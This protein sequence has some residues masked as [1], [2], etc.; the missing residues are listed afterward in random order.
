V[1]PSEFVET[2]SELYAKSKRDLAN[3][4]LALDR[5]LQT[6]HGLQAQVE[7]LQQE[8]DTYRLLSRD[9]M[10]QRDALSDEVETLRQGVR[11]LTA[12]ACNRMS[13]ST[14]YELVGKIEHLEAAWKRV[15]VVLSD[16]GCSC[17]FVELEDVIANPDDACLGHRIE[18]AWK[19]AP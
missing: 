13:A 6:I 9:H 1:S 4:E 19:G 5:E 2:L 12:M 18:A 3:L 7:A 11:D 16:E 15:G 8:C 10:L 17:D 14:Y